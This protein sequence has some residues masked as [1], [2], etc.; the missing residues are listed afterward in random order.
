LGKSYQKLYDVEKVTVKTFKITPDQFPNWFLLIQVIEYHFSRM[1]SEERVQS[2]RII[3]EAGKNLI[4]KCIAEEE[5]LR[6]A[7]KF[8][9][10]V[11][12]RIPDFEN[13]K[14]AFRSSCQAAI[15]L[16]QYILA[17]MNEEHTLLS[18]KEKAATLFS[19]QIK[20][21][22]EMKEVGKTVLDLGKETT[23]E[24]IEEFQ[25][26]LQKFSE[27]DSEVKLNVE[28]VEKVSEIPTGESSEEVKKVSRFPTEDSSE[29]VTSCDII[30]KKFQ[31]IL[32]MQDLQRLK[33]QE[34]EILVS[35]IKKLSLII[36][37]IKE[38]AKVEG[39]KLTPDYI[40]LKGLAKLVSESIANAKL[41]DLSAEKI[42]Q[43]YREVYDVDTI[44]EK[45][46]NEN[47]YE[48]KIKNLRAVY[49]EFKGKSLLI[50]VLC[51][52]KVSNWMK[53]GKLEKN[54]KQ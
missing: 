31:E 11:N 30:L 37:E 2:I 51:T 44:I 38:G 42:F 26:V 19:N 9:D 18:V 7:T 22:N 1:S 3:A 23:C 14:E 39:F 34:A 45:W 10:S 52:T 35:L 20:N 5:R 8:L 16:N 33:K 15:K 47:D 48:D 40:E 53:F 21:Y 4:S 49:K 41:D 54:K 50:C 46:T 24:Q 32:V 28:V 25:K 13:C 29:E 43:A 27:T 17:L 6:A 36:L 12:L